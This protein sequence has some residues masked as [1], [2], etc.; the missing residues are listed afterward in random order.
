MNVVENIAFPLLERYKLS[1]DEIMERV[2]DLLTPARPRTESV[3]I[4]QKFPPE[5]SGGQRKRVGL[6][7]ALIDRPEI[8]LYDEP[9]TG[10]DPVATKNVDEMIRRTARRLRRHL[11]RDLPRHGVHLPHRRSDLDARRRQDRR[12]RDSRGGAGEPGSGRCA[13][14]SRRPGWWRRGPGCGA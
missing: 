1:R 3:G 9:T 14:S 8:L 5:L 7:R 10:L 6:A 4:E 12:Q 11:G 13:S 2:R